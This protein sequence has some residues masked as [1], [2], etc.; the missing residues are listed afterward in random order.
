M[1]EILKKIFGIL[2]ALPAFTNLFKN[3]AQTGKVDPMEALNALTSISPSTKKCADIAMNT[4]SRGGSIPDAMKNLVNTG[5]VEAFG[6]KVNT[7]TLTQDLRKY[8][9]T[10]GG[11][12]ANWLDSVPNQSEK[13][14]VNFG[15]SASDLSNWAEI[16]K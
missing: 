8:G 16:I 1:T 4:I 6:Q 5:E 12:L 15:N 3:A 2:S 9:G 14:I 7:K 10:V 11:I 13:E